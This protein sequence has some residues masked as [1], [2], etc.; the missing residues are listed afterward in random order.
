[1]LQKLLSESSLLIR[2]KIAEKIVRPKHVPKTS[3][4]NI[5]EIVIPPEKRKEILTKIP[6]SLNDLTA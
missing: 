1:M 4:R 6:K 5:E 3:S 2:N